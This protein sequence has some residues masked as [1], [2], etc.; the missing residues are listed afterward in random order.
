MNLIYAEKLPSAEESKERVTEGETEYLHS[1]NTLFV[2]G[3]HFQ[4]KMVGVVSDISPIQDPTPEQLDE[5]R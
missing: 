3:A 4:S 2:N 5:I 1:Y